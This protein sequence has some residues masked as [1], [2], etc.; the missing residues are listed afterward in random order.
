MTFDDSMQMV[1]EFVAKRKKALNEEGKNTTLENIVLTS[2][3]KQI[4]Q[5]RLNFPKNETFPFDFIVNENDAGQG[6]GFPKDF[7]P[8][9]A[10]NVMFSSLVSLQMQMRAESIVLNQCSNFH[11]LMTD[12]VIN[13]CGSQNYLEEYKENDNPKYRMTCKW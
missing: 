10:D 1:K 6:S 8:G 7:K 11:R 12:L 2:E 13:G 3:D 9:S 4:V 5:A